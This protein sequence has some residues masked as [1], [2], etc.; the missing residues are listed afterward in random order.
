MC[1]SKG[2]SSSDDGNTN[3]SLNLREALEDQHLLREADGQTK[4]AV[5]KHR[6]PHWISDIAFSRLKEMG[7]RTAD[8][9]GHRQQSQDQDADNSFD[10]SSSDE[11]KPV[12]KSDEEAA[13][14]PTCLTGIKRC[15]SQV[16]K[17]RRVFG[18]TPRA[19]FCVTPEGVLH[20]DYGCQ[21]QQ[22]QKQQQHGPFPEAEKAIPTRPE[23][24]RTA[25]IVGLRDFNFRRVTGS[26]SD[27]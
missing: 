22:Q 14:S 13:P 2:Y 26:G 15:I 4:T 19:R 11:V 20:V 16:V 24:R 12:A 25:G 3:T 1:S 27:G 7:I 18:K 10:A 8:R 9:Q 17:H 5:T 21:Q 23:P 6:R